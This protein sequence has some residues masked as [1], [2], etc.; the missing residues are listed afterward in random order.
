MSTIEIDVLVV[1]AGPT[2]LALAHELRRHGLRCR[3]IDQ[4]EGPSI[5]SKAQAIHARTLELLERAG[6]AEDLLRDGKRIRQVNIY[7]AAGRRVAHMEI[8]GLDTA[9]PYIYS[10]AQRDTEIVLARCLERAGGVVERQL[11]LARFSQDEHGVDATLVHADGRE[12]AVRAAWLVGCDGAHSTVRHALELP[13][14]GSSYEVRIIQA[15]VRVDL[16]I[17]AEDD[18]A[19]VFF[20][21]GALV[22][23]LPLPGKHRYRMLVPR[24]PGDETD[25]TLEN[26]QRIF[27]A[28]G[29][30]GAVVDDPAW[31]IAFRLHCRMVGRYRVGRVF[32][33]GDAAHIHSPAGGQGMNMGIQDAFNLAWKLALCHHGRARPELLDSYHAERHPVAAATLAGTDAATSGLAFNLGLRSHT[34]LELRNRLVGFATSL[35]FLRRKLSRAASML[36]VHYPGSPIVA[37]DRPS[38]LGAH[39]FGQRSDEAPFV[40]DWFHFGHGP[41]PGDRAP[42]V[43]DPEIEDS[44]R[45]FAAF[46]PLRH[47]LLLFDGA[48][49]S[50]AGYRGLVALAERLEARF[51][52]LVAVRI[53]V[54]HDERPAPLAAWPGEVLQDADGRIHER[55]GARSECLYLIRPD[56]YV[57]Y[58]CQPADP[59]KLVAYLERIFV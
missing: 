16:P 45:L 28:V 6:I 29:P 49:A 27:T 36:D 56:G 18:E 4:G 3:V 35:G 54:P 11:R 9:Y 59:D 23:L 42:D 58:R 43:F 17:P 33:A 40:R 22:G 24:P 44:P 57:A 5:W 39:V 51:P 12:E 2:G 26:F 32:L 46:D 7:G 41:A 1:G 20:G 21:E 13:F 8:E 55:Y 50:E 19:V 38:L 15:D 31:M 10:L 37:Q 30:P 48:S 52:G 34:A 14:E 53:V 25:A 47:T